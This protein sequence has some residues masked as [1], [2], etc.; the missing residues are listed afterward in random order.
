[1]I[2]GYLIA[3]RHNKWVDGDWQWVWSRGNIGN[4]NCASLDLLHAT[5]QQVSISDR[6]DSWL[7]DC[8]SDGVFTVKSARETIDSILLPLS[9]SRTVW[10]KF[11]P[12]K[13]NNFLWRLN[14]NSLSVRWN[15]SAKDVEISTIVCPTCN[16]EIE[17]RDHLFLEC[18]FAKEIW[19]KRLGS[20]EGD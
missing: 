9:S 2:V 7:F 8:S 12:R 13:V 3:Y 20:P 18:Q 5:L 11:I 17:T 10:F 15:L 6:D 19:H 4:R 1:M 16:N 14:L